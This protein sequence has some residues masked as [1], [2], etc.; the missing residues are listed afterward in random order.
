MTYD[1][2]SEKRKTIGITILQFATMV[3]YSENAIK[4]WKQKDNI[5]KWAEIVLEHLLI[6]KQLKCSI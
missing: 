2:F 6:K 5:P 4:K 1:K 3:G